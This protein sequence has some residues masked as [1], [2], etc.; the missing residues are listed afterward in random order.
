MPKKNYKRCPKKTI[1]MSKKNYKRC[2]KK[3]IKDAQKREVRFHGLL[4]FC[5]LVV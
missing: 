5:Q 1:N 3:T 2:P 4:W